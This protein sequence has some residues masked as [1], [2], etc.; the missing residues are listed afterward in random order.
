[1]GT[2]RGLHSAAILLAMALPNAPSTAAG[3]LP[4]FTSVNADLPLGD[5]LFQGPG[6]D[7]I[8]NNCLIC[9]SAGMVLT[10]P[11]LTRAGWQ[12]IVAKMRTAYK[13]PVA[14]EDIGPIVDYLTRIKGAP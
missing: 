3:E 7:A 11:P 1:M 14:D 6:A 2:S 8:N 4:A 9:H 10:Q 5:G 13:A 12:G